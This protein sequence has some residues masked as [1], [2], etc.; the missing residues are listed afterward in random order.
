M[1]KNITINDTIVRTPADRPYD[2]YEHLE[3]G[4]RESFEDALGPDNKEPL[5]FTNVENLYD[6]F[7]D[8]IPE[9]AR[10]HYKSCSP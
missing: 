4:I 8:H 5:F 9:E 10:Q 1:S 6:I 3:A 7:L 2:G